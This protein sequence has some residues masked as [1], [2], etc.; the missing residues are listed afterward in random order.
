MERR[1][2]FARECSAAFGISIEAVE[3]AERAVRGADVIVTMTNA[4]DP[5]LEAG[6]VEP[7]AHINAAGA[8]QANRRELPAELV[9]AA[10][11]I[12]VDSI[13]QAR[14]ESG[15]LILALDEAGWRDPKLVELAEL[16]SGKR[17]IE[18]GNRPTIF[19]SNGLGVQDVAAAG[20][21]YERMKNYS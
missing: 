13:E 4:K 8:N 6:W 9:R 18:R 17:T 3:T 16:A 20:F 10:G 11:L 7:H 21:V 5:V 12:A 1:E 19:K 14:G 2:Q 15:D